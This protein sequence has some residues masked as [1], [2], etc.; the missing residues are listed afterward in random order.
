MKIL[1]SLMLLF[2]AFTANSQNFI[3]S[4]K[5]VNS[6][7]EPLV[8]ATVAVK[9][10]K[11]GTSSDFEGGFK[12]SLAKGTYN[13]TVSYVGFKTITQKVDITAN[14]TVNFQLT[15]DAN[16]LD[17][18]LVSAVRVKADAP[19]THSNLTKK[20]IAKR[21]LG[22]DIP[23]LMN[24]LPNVVSSSD[25]G[26]GIGYT[27]IRVRGSDASRVNVT[28]NGIPYNDAESQGTF[29][30]N[31][32]DFASSTQSLQLQRGVGTS[33][34]GSGAFGASL[35]ILTDA[36][37]EEAGGEISNSFGS[38]GTR[39][40]TVK[41]TTGKVNEHFEF[42]GRLSNIYSDGYIDKAFTD[43][44]SYFL[45]GSYTDDNTLIKALVFGGKEKT[46]Q[47]W[48]GIDLKQLQTN[49]RFN[50]YTYD[51]ETDNYQQDHYQ[52]HWNEKINKNWST[53]IGL[54]YTRGKGYFEQYKAGRDAADYNNLIVDGS[55]VIVRRWLDNHFYV[56]N[57]NVTYKKDNLEIITGGSYSKYDN[58]HYGEVIWGSDLAPNANIRDHY[59]DS[60]SK[61][62]DLSIFSKATFNVTDNLKAFVDIQGRFVNYKTSGLT[63]DRDPIN[64]DKD[65]NFFNPKAGLTY[66]VNDEH[67]LYVSYAKANREPNRN[68]F[69]GGNSKHESLDDY[70]LG[71][72]LS[73]PVAKINTNIYYMDYQNQLILT[74]AIDPNTGEPLR[75]SSGSSYRLGIEIDADLKLSEQVSMRP[76]IAFSKN[77]NRDYHAKIDGVLQNLGN[78]TI[79]FSPDIVF[80]NALVYKPVK[81]LQLAFLS[82]Y[83]GKQFMSNL[84]SRVSD[85]DVLEGFFTSD[86]NLVYEIQTNKIF[87]SIVF[88]ALVNNIFNKEYVDRGYYFTYDD[89]WTNPGTTTTVDG[90]GYYPQA[91]RNFLIGATLKF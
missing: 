51:N 78:T 34:N 56:A 49:R 69:E 88:T 55:D 70:E 29:W 90:S 59:Y 73:T 44:K 9:S 53:N 18:V 84:D 28:V 25:A 42:A 2:A 32:G 79:T 63:S 52:L 22:Q 60:A 85:L 57:G 41:F 65:Y 37:A 7:Q 33:T 15:S 14:Q 80:G 5:V 20:E 8:G 68:D 64:V 77:I 54:N 1:S 89:T 46:F 10:L 82:K 4:G 72:R 75:A 3:L 6:Q 36:V 30:V 17:E 50:P 45:Q 24:Y 48:A 27:Y 38:Y 12:L 81:N 23:I 11:K 19:V 66:K 86:L 31:M 35:N 16:V 91:T 71:W 47:A 67:S 62:T 43:L 83:V 40:H 87:K 61:K 74:G 13:V 39:K 76:N 58:D 26:A 21:N